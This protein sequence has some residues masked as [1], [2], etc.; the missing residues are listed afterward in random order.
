MVHYSAAVL[1]VELTFVDLDEVSAED[2][3]HVR[4]AY[5]A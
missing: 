4:W 1:S 2:I 3:A 5:F